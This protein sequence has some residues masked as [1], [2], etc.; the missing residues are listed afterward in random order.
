MVLEGGTGAGEGG[1][2]GE[3]GGGGLGIAFNPKIFIKYK[4]FIMYSE[5]FI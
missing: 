1:R 3:R 2:G 4:L 5:T